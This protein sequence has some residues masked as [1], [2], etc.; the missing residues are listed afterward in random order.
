MRKL[1]SKKLPVSIVLF[2]CLSVAG[3]SSKPREVSASIPLVKPT[4]TPIGELIPERYWSELGDPSSTHLTHSDY[5]IK[6]SAPY[7][8]GL[9]NTCRSLDIENV[10]KDKTNRIACSQSNIGVNGEFILTW[11]LTPDIVE[12]A[13]AVKIQ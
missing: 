10:N 6:L 3:C 9:G 8:S 7:T 2:G 4:T 13:T 1:T 12:A 11:F 5:F